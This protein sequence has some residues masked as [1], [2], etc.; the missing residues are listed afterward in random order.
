[1]FPH[2][3]HQFDM[4]LCVKNLRD[5]INTQHLSLREM[6]TQLVLQC[7]SFEYKIGKYQKLTGQL[8]TKTFEIINIL[9]QI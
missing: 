3:L 2:D 5:E 8:G 4:E 9:S 7:N 1:M 6:L